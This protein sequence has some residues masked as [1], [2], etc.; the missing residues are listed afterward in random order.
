MFFIFWSPVKYIDLPAYGCSTIINI[1][2]AYYPLLIVI[3]IFNWLKSIIKWV[4]DIVRIRCRTLFTP[5]RAYINSLYCYTTH[6]NKC[7]G[8]II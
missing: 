4:G 8:M 6:L 2:G 5:N 7:Y 1:I 3:K